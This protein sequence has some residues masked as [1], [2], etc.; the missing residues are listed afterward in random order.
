[1][2]VEVLPLYACK[3]LSLSL[4][5]LSLFVN[6]ARICWHMDALAAANLL[7]NSSGLMLMSL[8][9]LGRLILPSSKCS[10]AVNSS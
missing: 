8:F 1:M 3:A 2:T 4:I 7:F 10:E 9:F 5:S 6:S